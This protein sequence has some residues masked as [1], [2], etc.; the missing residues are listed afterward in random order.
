MQCVD[1]RAGLVVSG[2]GIQGMGING[3]K[4][5]KRAH[6]GSIHGNG[7]VGHGGNEKDFIRSVQVAFYRN[8]FGT[9]DGYR[10]YLISHDIGTSAIGSSSHR[11]ITHGN[12]NGLVGRN[13]ASKRMLAG[14]SRRGSSAPSLSFIQ[15][16][17]KRNI[18]CVALDWFFR[19]DL[20]D[21]I[22]LGGHD[23][24]GGGR[25]GVAVV[26]VV[27]KRHE[28]FQSQGISPLECKNVGVQI[29]GRIDLVIRL[30]RRGRCD[31]E[32]KI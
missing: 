17:A 20:N 31:V 1:R 3:G 27:L 22:V 23:V 19:G 13:D 28:K 5:R 10:D 15:H 7:R 8:V 11:I 4:G 26:Q 2:I 12:R 25:L 29:V 21:G 6:D 30:Y 16:N 9:Y 24:E 18:W 14:Q 32:T